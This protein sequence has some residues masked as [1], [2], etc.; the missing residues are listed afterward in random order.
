MSGAWPVVKGGQ[1]ECP[2]LEQKILQIELFMGCSVDLCQKCIGGRGSAPD[3]T[4]GADD[5]L[6]VPDLL[7]GR[8]TPVPMPY[9]S[10]RLRRLDSRAFGASILMPPVESWVALGF[11]GGHEDRSAE[12]ARIQ[13]P[14]APRGVGH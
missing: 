14:K 5:A 1:P 4:G 9:S 3:P 7:L 10:R 11:H 2:P 12:G 8:E 13:A 6:P